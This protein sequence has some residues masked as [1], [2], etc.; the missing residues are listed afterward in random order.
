MG[1]LQI[2]INLAL[3]VILTLVIKWAT[4]LTDA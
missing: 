1:K 4:D 3:A 2:I